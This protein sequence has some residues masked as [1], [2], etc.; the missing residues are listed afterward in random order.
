MNK[1]LS[2]I[3]V[4][5]NSGDLLQ[6]TV[7]T[8]KPLLDS[9]Y[10]EYIIIDGGS[11]D[12]SQDLI[13][14]EASLI[15]VL[16]QEKDSGIYDAMNK[17]ISLASTNWLWFV[18]SGDIILLDS[19]TLKSLLDEA[20]VNNNNL[21]YSDLKTN[22][23]KIRQNIDVSNLA[24]GML[25]HQNIIYHRS[26]FEKYLYDI[27]FKFC[28]DYNHFLKIYKSINSLKSNHELCLYD[29]EGVSSENSRRVRSLI[30]K[31]RI[32]AQYGSTLPFYLKYPFITFSSIVLFFKW[33]FPGFLRKKV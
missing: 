3:T 11:T 30:W 20:E 27:S 25:N 28:A 8:M 31:E 4:N 32:K 17:G 14:N 26:N 1:L 2:I 12:E 24:R 23:K 19:V 29:T 10:I 16:V 18:N 22:T 9:Q 7:D 21:I 15:D 33:C 5:Y 6:K 13:K